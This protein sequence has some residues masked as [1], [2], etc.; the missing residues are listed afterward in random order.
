MATFFYNSKNPKD[1]LPR[2]S[3][4]L[5]F[6]INQCLVSHAAHATLFKLTRSAFATGKVPQ[7]QP[8]VKHL[9]Q[10]LG[11]NGVT[12]QFHKPSLITTPIFNRYTTTNAAYDTIPE[13]S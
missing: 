6:K 12:L 7:E 4:I 13:M 8:G 2:V 11:G 9:A 1:L 10:G 5:Y 3:K